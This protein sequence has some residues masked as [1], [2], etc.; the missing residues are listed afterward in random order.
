M[1][2]SY[3]N[4][5]DMESFTWEGWH[6]LWQLLVSPRVKFFNWLYLHSRIQTYDLLHALTLTPST[7]CL[8]C[9]LYN[10][11]LEHLLLECPR[12]Q[13]V[14]LNT[15]LALHASLGL[16]DSI[17]NGNQFHK[18]NSKFFASIIAT[19]IWLIWKACCDLIF[20]SVQPNFTKIV[21]CVVHHAQEY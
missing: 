18:D 2:Y 12:V 1:V 15:E 14:W 6:K 21:T 7:L 13:N 20:K 11:T 5:R 3:F 10:E 16:D 4:H 8:I 9:G 17:R 19:T